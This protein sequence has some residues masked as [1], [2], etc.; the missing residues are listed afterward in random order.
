M[1]GGNLET[2]EGSSVGICEYCGTKQT[3]PTAND[4]N[5]QGLYNRAN[6]LRIKSEFDK[7]E[8]LYEKIL[9]VDGNQAE[10]Y[11]GLILCKYG[12]E[13][14]E[15][16]ATF[17]RIPTCHRASYDSIIADD[18]YK[19]ALKYADDSQRNIYEQEAK[20][21]DRIQKE[22]IELSSK[23][24]PYD[25][26]ICYKETD[27][28]GSRTQ[29]SVIANDIYY[30]LTQEGF[31]VFYA[32]ITLEDKLGSAYEPCIFAALNSAKVML[33]IGTKPEYFNAVWV[34]N[35]WSRYLKIMK[36]D[37]SKLLIPCYKNMDAYDL[38]DEFAHLQAQDMGKIGF[39]NDVVRGIKKV[40][41]RENSKS[42]PVVNV[43]NNTTTKPLLKRAFIFLED[44]DWN[45]ANEYC[46][47]VLDIDPE[48]AQAYLGKLMAELHIKKQEY[49]KNLNETFENNSNYIKT[50][51]YADDKLKN[52]LIGYIDS[53]NAKAEEIRKNNILAEAKSKM[54][55]ENIADYEYA[56]QLLESISGWKDSYEIIATCKN[57]IADI[58]AKAEAEQLEKQRQKEITEKE[59]ARIAKRNKKIT[60]IMAPIVAVII[61]GVFIFV[62]FV[63]PLLK[64]NEATK[65]IASKDYIEAY[66]ALCESKN[67][68]NTQKEFY[69]L[70]QIFL[71]DNNIKYAALSFGRANNYE[72]SKEKSFELWRKFISTQTISI[73]SFHTIA[74]TENGN[75]IAKGDNENGQCNVQDWKNIISISANKDH[76]I[77]LKYDGTV[78]STG[79][80][81]DAHKI[82]LVN[83]W[84][85]V[86]AISSGYWETVG[87][88]NDGTIISTDKKTN[89]S[90]KNWNDII[91]IS[92]GTH[93]VVALRADGSVV[94]TGDN[95]DGECNV[96]DWKDIVSVSAGCGFTIGL[97]SD[98]TVLAVGDN[99]TNQ[100][101][102]ENWKDISYIMAAYNHAVGFNSQ[103]KMF[104]T[105]TDNIN[106]IW[107]IDDWNN[108]VEICSN[109]DSLTVALNTDGTA[110]GTGISYSWETGA[111]DLE[112]WKEIKMPSRQ[113]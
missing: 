91:A 89:S 51:R 28:T 94:A 21:I 62:T 54:V 88:K 112:S 29:D 6:T 33:A 63:S 45:S 14:V 41:S 35:E 92:V 19:S 4:E 68:L 53:I 78:V 55:G 85:N 108:I 80:D 1:C 9:Q 71:E 99:S 95:Y 24:E 75:V 20:E 64:L 43:V 36:K 49:L 5:L 57:K 111:C 31:K 26:F 18:D 69:N 25:V 110:V 22:I 98:G 16:P 60:L 30:Q 8:Q 2:T 17:K 50:I 104:Q 103:G 12:I 113:R 86:V 90:A 42:T 10:A 65:L 100:C 74:L 96:E 77:G 82:S 67:N 38:P 107:E 27:D 59:K 70:G 44:G 56:I 61:A 23:E 73:G 34:K 81:S 72:K 15:D 83:E 105:G 58:R 7:A 84:E 52:E 102:V 39:I 93:H 76:S 3:V 66:Y 48:C 106:G 32:A 37:R 13:Y 87:L 47:K 97:K 79:Y 46:E 109:S 40:V 101:S 11:W